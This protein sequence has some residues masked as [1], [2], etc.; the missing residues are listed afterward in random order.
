LNIL[1][2]GN[3]GVGTGITAGLKKLGHNSRVLV[4]TPHPFGF[5]EDIILYPKGEPA[6]F[7]TIIKLKTLLPLR[8][9]DIFHE[10]MLNFPFYNV[11]RLR[12][13]KA[14]RV[15][16]YHSSS[17]NQYEQD[18][19]EGIYHAKFLAVPT[20]LKVNKNSIWIP[21][22]VDTETK[23]LPN[24]TLEK[25]EVIVGVGSD[26]SDH[27]KGKFLRMD[28]V[29]KAIKNLQNKGYKIATLEFKNYKHDKVLDYWKKIDIFL[30]R[31]DL[32]FYGFTVPEAAS[33]GIP[34]LCDIEEDMEQYVPNC[35]FL[36][37]RPAVDSIESNLEYLLSL[38][39]R[40]QLS[41]KCREFAIQKHDIVKV[42][43]KCLEEYKKILN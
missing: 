22:P 19:P 29:N 20:R 30:D 8:D 39:N 28:L 6:H 4:P 37:T 1:H 26:F 41:K 17:R 43:A 23:K 13:T 31:F 35:P 32:G 2:I 33:C 36:R 40:E 34:V 24:P 15:F 11:L 14:K 10:H 3:S 9:V 12:N 18:P 7:R 5:K 38:S 27:T 16:H 42:A 25:N 21:L